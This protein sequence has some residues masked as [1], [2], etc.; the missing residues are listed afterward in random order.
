[1]LASKVCYFT[2][3][4]IISEA[5]SGVGEFIEFKQQ[6]KSRRFTVCLPGSNKVIQAD[7]A[8]Y[9][10]CKLLYLDLTF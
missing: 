4:T 8:V 5:F 3:N 10:L 6:V 2:Y 1:M 7:V 9:L